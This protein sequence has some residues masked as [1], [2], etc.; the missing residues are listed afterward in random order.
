MMVPSEHSG[1]VGSNYISK[2]SFV[3]QMVPKGLAL[4]ELLLY[5]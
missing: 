4:W 2:M 1:S 5:C 3:T